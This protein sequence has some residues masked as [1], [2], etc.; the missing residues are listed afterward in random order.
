MKLVELVQFMWWHGTIPTYLV[1]IILIL[2]PNGNRDTQ[3][4][5]LLEVLW[6][7]MEAVIDTRI[8][9]AVVFHD[10]LHEFCAGRGTGK[11]IIDIN[12]VQDLA[13]V[14]QDSLFLMLLD[15]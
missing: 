7:V 15:L 14:D 13:T 5:R 6:N 2:V 4:I 3:G 8:K 9:K 10:F 12:L 1:F 11:F